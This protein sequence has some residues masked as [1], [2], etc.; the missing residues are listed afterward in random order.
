[1]SQ[2]SAGRGGAYRLYLGL[3]LVGAVLPY[4]ILLPWLAR[5]GL[6]VTQFLAGPFANG[7]ASI[8]SADV[9]FSA[10][11]FLTFVAVEGRRLGMRRLWV[12]PL[13]VVAIGLCCALP[14]FLAQ[15]E[16]A[17]APHG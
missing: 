15:R 13:I 3:A 16:R 1:M 9:L 11:V 12:P 10:A 8:F 6:D 2:A 7:P 17:L 4:A 5:H 14:L